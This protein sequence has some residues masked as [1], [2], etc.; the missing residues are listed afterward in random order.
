VPTAKKKGARKSAPKVRLTPKIDVA[1]RELLKVLD[2]L[3]AG[4]RINIIRFNSLV[5]PWKTELT[6]L[7]ASTRGEAS[8][9]VQASKP[10]GLTNAYAALEEAFK[11]QKLDTIYFLS[12]GA[13]TLGAHI[14]TEDLL[15]AVAKMNQLRKV[16]INTIGFHL[17]ADEKKLMEAL[18]DQNY[19]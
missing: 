4:V 11:D 7:D 1:K 9:F 10:D 17:N 8:G 5:E 16:K 3:P 18:A 15:A 14:E 19:G 6:A 2:S 12:D 13:P